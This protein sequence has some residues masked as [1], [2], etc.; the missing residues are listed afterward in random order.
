MFAG[1]SRDGPL[2]RVV[3]GTLDGPNV[4]LEPWRRHCP[5]VRPDGA[6]RVPLPGFRFPPAQ[7]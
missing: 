6:V 5:T 3:F 4:P 1:T 7:R 2:E